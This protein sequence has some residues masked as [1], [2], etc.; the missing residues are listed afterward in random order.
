V[1]ISKDQ[2][3]SV[4]IN[5]EDHLRIQVLR[6]GFQLKKAWARSTTSTPRSRTT[7]TTPFRPTLGYLTAC[8]TNLG[9]AMRARR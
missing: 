3:L 1:V 4:M 2:V 8:P 7:S 5:E 9:T 6:A